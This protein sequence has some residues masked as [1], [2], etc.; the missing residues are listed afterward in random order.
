MKKNIVS[1]PKIFLKRLQKQIDE[2]NR[3]KLRYQPM[4]II[5]EKK[6][7]YLIFSYFACTSNV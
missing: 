1:P 7:V 2:I 6:T 5:K 4:A 3:K